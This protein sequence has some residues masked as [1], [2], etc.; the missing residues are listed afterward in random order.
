MKIKTDKKEGGNKERVKETKK[1]KQAGR[2]EGINKE[3][4]EGRK[5]KEWKQEDRMSEH[6]VSCVY[7][8][9]VCLLFA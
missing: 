8:E 7:K 6:G 1:R 2:K 3:R 9:F 5:K 4:K